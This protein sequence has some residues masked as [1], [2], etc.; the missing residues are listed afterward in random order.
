M[1]ARKRKNP[2]DQ[3]LPDYVSVGKS[4]WEYKAPGRKSQALRKLVRDDSGD[5]VRNPSPEVKAEVLDAYNALMKSLQESETKNMSYWFTK[6]LA[7]DVFARLGK[8]TQ[9]DYTRYIEVRVNPDNPQSKATHNGLRYKFGDM[10]PLKV[11]KIHIRR[12]MDY[13]ASPRSV[14]LASGRVL[15]SDGSKTTANRHL[16]CLQKFFK[17]LSQYLPGMAVN[18]AHDVIRFPENQRKVYITDDQYMAILESSQKNKTPWLFAFLEISYLCGLRLSEVLEL[19]VD[20]LVTK[21]GVDYLVCRRKKGS[22]GEMIEIS[23]RLSNAIA[24]A[25]SCHKRDGVE[26]MKYRPLLRSGTGERVT[27]KAAHSAM[28]RMRE[29]TGI[30]DVIIHDMKKKAGSEGKDLRHKTKRMA[31]LYNLLLPTGQATR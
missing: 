4:S 28:A 1:A 2:L 26:P 9:S 13:W 20:D 19:N 10:D 6:F 15:K 18:P 5:V 17:W 16:T 21:D 14:T 7:S 11:T 31:E 8:D 12:Y 22:G 24:V 23:D 3:W 30:K 27:R 25:M 29:R